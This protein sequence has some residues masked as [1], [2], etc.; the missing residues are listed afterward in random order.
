VS[1]SGDKLVILES[2]N[3]IAKVAHYL[4]SGFRVAA[5]CGHVREIPT[6]TVNKK[7]PLDKKTWDVNFVVSDSKKDIV[8]FLK[9]EAG[10]A[11]EIYLATD[12]DREGEAIAWH[13]AELLK[14]STRAPFY[15]LTFNA[16]TQQ[17]IQQAL[18]N[19][20]SVNMDMVESQKT[21]QVM[22]RL[23][24]FSLSPLVQKAEGGKS[25]GRVQSVALTFVANRQKEINSFV[26]DEFWELD[27]VA[28]LDGFPAKMRLFNYKDKPI[29]ITTE[30]D[31]IRICDEVT[32]IKKASIV[33]VKE[34]DK[35]RKPKAP[36]TTSTMQQAASTFLNMSLKQTMDAAQKL[37]EGAHISYHRSDSVRLEPEQIDAARDLILQNYGKAYLPA[38]PIIY[39]Q[40]SAS[41]VQDAHTAIQPTHPDV[42]SITG[43]S[44]EQK[45]YAL[46]RERFLA[47]QAAD[48][49]YKTKTIIVQIG[50]YKFKLAGSH[51]TFDGFLK[52]MGRDDED[53][54]DGNMKVPDVTTKSLVGFVKMDKTQ[55][56]T[57]PPP[58]FN[59]ASL[60]KTLEANGVGRPSTYAS[61]IDTLLD[62]KYT[63]KDGKKLVATELGIKVSDYLQTEC[64][65]FINVGFTADM[66]NQLNE[67]EDGKKKWT[68]VLDKF[69]LKL[70]TSVK[71]AD[72]KL[73]GF[74]DTGKK[75]PDC[76][77]SVVSGNGRF[78]PFCKCSNEDCKTKFDKEGNYKAPLPVVGTCKKCGCD[79]V[80][81][82]S[83][84]GT[85]L[86]CSGFPKCRTIYE[87]SSKGELI[88]K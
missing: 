55:K 7:K 34:V 28:S 43:S 14:G 78:G 16:I 13:L 51:I 79:V 18:K 72:K 57:N 6:K 71:A 74:Q 87:L 82:Q 20:S 47:C 68:G 56:F 85:F 9:K 12:P 39:T 35:T 62:R 31:A 46:I 75:C 61:V 44:A 15:R 81:R 26:P 4:G 60:V 83:F 53:E 48:C 37:F 67:I 25:A 54:S 21:R 88:A 27:L 32:K 33:E 65:D 41:K 23:V 80:E 30:Q 10:T 45:L 69:W 2:P 64:S 59:D 11:K 63:E 49:K 19:K 36:F 42:S 58:Y 73:G 17:A 24:G 76:G 29:K 77:S 40:K 1:G 66:E 86:A 84:K 8:D 70:D 3:K 52:V 38:S 5:S 50:D 22:D